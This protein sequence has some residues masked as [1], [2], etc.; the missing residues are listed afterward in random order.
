MLSSNSAQAPAVVQLEEQMSMHMT[1]RAALYN[2]ISGPCY[3][4]ARADM[5]DKE[6]NDGPTKQGET[7]WLLSGFMLGATKKGLVTGDAMT[8]EFVT[9]YLNDSSICCRRLLRSSI[10]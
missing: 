10:A 1:V 3:R 8:R 6:G 5:H 7:R 4:S 2:H 9:L